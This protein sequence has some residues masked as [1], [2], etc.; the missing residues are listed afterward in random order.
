V[1]TA[2]RTYLPAADATVLWPPADPAAGSYGSAAPSPDLATLVACVQT[3]VETIAPDAALHERVLPDGA[4]HLT[5]NLGDAAVVIEGAPGHLG[6]GGGA[7]AFGPTCAPTVIRMAGRVDAVGVQLRPGGALALLGVPA[8]A[9]AGRTVPLDALW[10]P[11][12]EETRERLAAVPPG[13]ARVTVVE[14]ALRRR[15]RRARGEAHAGVAA[16]VEQI[17]AADGRRSV[18]ALAEAVGVGERRLEQLFRAHVGISP[19]AASRL[20]RF[21]ASLRLLRREPTRRWSEIAHAAGFADHAHLVHE[22]RALTGLTPGDLRRRLGFG[23]PQDDP[24][25]AR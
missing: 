8:A 3:G 4:V 17:A 18:R 24:A 25:A 23:F 21:Q 16:A 15:L 9:L 10:G 13:A 2:E 6:S 11:L 5:F 1:P 12:A 7:E 22:Y 19:K 14:A 20:A